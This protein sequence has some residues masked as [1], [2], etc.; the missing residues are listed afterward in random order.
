MEPDKYARMSRIAFEAT[1]RIARD[2]DCDVDE[3]VFAALLELSAMERRI[4]M[5][6][7]D[8]SESYAMNKK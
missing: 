3:V 5:H 8:D 4:K 1:F 6:L 2:F 7:V